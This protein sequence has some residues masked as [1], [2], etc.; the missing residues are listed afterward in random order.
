L[1][2]NVYELQPETYCIMD[3]SCVGSDVQDRQLERE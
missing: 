3:S 2:D 1:K